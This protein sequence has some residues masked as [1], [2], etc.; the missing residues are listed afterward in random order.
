MTGKLLGSFLT[1]RAPLS[2]LDKLWQPMKGLIFDA[3]L[4]SLEE[5]DLNLRKALSQVGLL[6]RSFPTLLAPAANLLSI[7]SVAFA[8]LRS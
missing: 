3:V 5:E 7:F 6:P 8:E 4:R 2:R 1:L